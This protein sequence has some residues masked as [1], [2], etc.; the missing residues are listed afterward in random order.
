MRI[1]SGFTFVAQWPII[2]ILPILFF[3]GRGLLGAETGWYLVFGVVMVPVLI[4]TLAIPPLITLG[5]SKVRREKKER[6]AYSIASWI[7]WGALVVAALTLSDQAD[8]APYQSVLSNWTGG[9]LSIEASNA[10]YYI[11]GG[12]TGLA[13]LATFTLAIAGISRSK[14]EN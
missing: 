11:A 4:I 5:D 6:F 14:T 8:G 13:Y 1:W 12:I 7:L 10:I 9:A 3:F 2:V